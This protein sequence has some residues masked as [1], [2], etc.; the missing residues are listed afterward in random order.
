MKIGFIFSGQGSQY[1]GMGKE[2]YDNYDSFREICERANKA[3]GFNITEMM[4]NGSKD[5]LNITENTQPAIL[6]MSSGI[7]SIL[8]E[9]GIEADV[10]A[11]LSLG[12]YSALYA[13]SAID[14]ESCVK[15]VKNR[16][17]Y[18]QE[19]VPVG[20]GKMAAIIGVSEKKLNEVMLKAQ[21]KG[22][23][24]ICNYNTPKQ[25]VI[26]G[27]QEA[28]DMAMELSVEA[29]ARRAIPLKVS[30]PFH[31]PLLEPASIK[32]K[33]ELENIEFNDMKIP[34]ITNVTADIIPNK[35]LIKEI[36]VKQV[37]SPVKWSDSIRRMIDMGVT[38][39]VEIG[40]GRTLSGFMR[41]IDRNVKVFNVEDIKSL[42]KTLEG[43][44]I[45]NA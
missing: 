45:E 21:E 18:M 11:G 16:G 24:V 15:L 14:F 30:G 26:G 22:V 2:L 29:G 33:N 31:T 20:I 8:N 43:M 23:V 28:V 35:E 3:L 34:V 6:T 7:L 19:A 36:L 39:F 25:L 12:E 9:N 4:F 17:K 5:Q 42:N 37:K 10:V 40:P 13:S 44:K 38:T 41:E 32:L 27:E 1:V